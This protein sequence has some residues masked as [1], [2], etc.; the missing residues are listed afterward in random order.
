[1][2]NRTEIIKGNCPACG[3]GLIADLDDNSFTAIGD[4]AK[5]PKESSGGESDPAG[6][7][8][9]D[10]EQGSEQ[11][12]EADV[13]SGSETDEQ[14]ETV[15]DPD[16]ESDDLDTKETKSNKGLGDW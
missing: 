2:A 12:R 4:T 10:D 11:D 9:A 3:C 5:K 8:G 13:S 15:G 14:K 6:T 1:M 7:N 16:H